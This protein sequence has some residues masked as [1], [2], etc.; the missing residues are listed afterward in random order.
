MWAFAILITEVLTRDEPYPDLLPLQVAI[1]V[2]YESLKPTAPDGCTDLIAGIIDA[3]TQTDP[4]QRPTFEQIGQWLTSLQ[5]VW[6][7]P[8]R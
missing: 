4:R 3:A 8:Q 2:A 6:R 1:K 7:D 5:S